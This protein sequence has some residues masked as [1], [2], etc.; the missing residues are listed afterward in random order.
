MKVIIILAIVGAAAYFGYQHLVRDPLAA[1]DVIENPVY[2]DIRLDMRVA[3]RDLQIALFGKMASQSDCEQRSR[4]A[5]GKLIEGCK[6]CVQ[7]TSTCK[8]QLEPRYQ[9]LFDDVPIPS[10]Y[11]TLNRGSEYERDGRM[12]IFGLTA[13]EG[14]MI[15]EQTVARFQSS[16]TGKMSCVK[17]R[18]D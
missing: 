15:C 1:P 16:Y 12:V 7:R 2:A 5:W 10:T 14:D 3:R 11:I 17:A 6:E 4:L 13:D 8:A 18:R 9:R